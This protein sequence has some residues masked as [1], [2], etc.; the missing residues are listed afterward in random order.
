M[1]GMFRPMRSETYE[2]RVR[3]LFAKD[4]HPSSTINAPPGRRREI[5]PPFELEMAQLDSRHW[6]T[7][8]VQV[9]PSAAAAAWFRV[10]L[11]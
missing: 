4:L 10:D 7:Q 3:A 6:A 11:C 2:A 8:L 5:L 1:R 9:V